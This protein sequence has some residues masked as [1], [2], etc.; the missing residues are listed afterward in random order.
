MPE[1]GERPQRVD[2]AFGELGEID[3]RPEQL[4]AALVGERERQQVADRPAHP[5][6]VLTHALERRA[7][8]RCS[9]ASRN[10]TSSSARIAAS[11]VRNSCDAS[12]DELAP[13]GN[14]GLE[15]VEHRVERRRQP[16][17]LVARIRRAQ[18]LVELV[19]ADL[20]GLPAHP[21]DRQQR[22]AHEQP[23]GE[24][25]GDEHDRADDQQQHEHLADRL[26][27]PGQR[28]GDDDDLARAVAGERARRHPEGLIAV[29]EID[30]VDPGSSGRDAARRARGRAAGPERGH[31]RTARARARSGRAPGR[32]Q[33]CD[34][35][36]P[37]L[38]R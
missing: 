28:F 22:V 38:P 20:V 8:G 14:A 30:I 36:T 32:P 34:A 33:P 12:A 25:G 31:R 23:G 26:V 19:D 29:A 4:E 35:A 1:R 7:L 15:P 3:R 2:R 27:D 37:R 24:C 21:I 18:A 17:D 11:G 10:V 16:S 9:L 5:V 6:D 13:G